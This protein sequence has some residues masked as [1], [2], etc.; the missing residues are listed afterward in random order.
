[1]IYVNYSMLKKMYACNAGKR[2]FIKGNVFRRFFLNQKV[3]L[4]EIMKTH[5]SMDDIYWL[6]IHLTKRFTIAE[7]RVLRK[8]ALD[9]CSNAEIY[10]SHVLTDMDENDRNENYEY[11]DAPV[12]MYGV[13]QLIRGYTKGVF[14]HVENKELIIKEVMSLCP[15]LKGLK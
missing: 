12:V 11:L 9:A 3:S 7:A 15:T 6:C 2:R 13:A 10:S 14:N 1:M 4:E 5:P 8:L